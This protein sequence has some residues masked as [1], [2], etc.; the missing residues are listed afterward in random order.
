[1]SP[2]IRAKCSSIC[3]DV[4]SFGDLAVVILYYIQ[5]LSNNYRRVDMVFDRYFDTSLKEDTRKGR[6]IGSRFVF[7]E[8]TPLPKNMTEDCLMNS[9]NK[10]HFNEFLAKKFY[11]LYQGDQIFIVTYRDGVLYKPATEQIYNTNVSIA[12]CQSEEADQRLIRHVLHCVSS[13]IYKRIV[14]RTIDT[15]VLVLRV[16]Y[17]NLSND[18]PIEIYAQMINSHLFYDIGKLIVYFGSQICKAMPFF[19]AF[20][21][22]DIVSS[23]FW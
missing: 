12:N 15:D 2:V 22:C 6:G 1:M 18:N 13:E 14:V 3:S 16:S 11:E 17:L 9:R 8:D 23:F 21:G 19:Y 4:N 20:T 10:N 7:T 5:S